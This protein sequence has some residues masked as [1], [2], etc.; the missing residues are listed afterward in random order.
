MPFLDAGMITYP[1]EVAE[2]I[3]GGTSIDLEFLDAGMWVNPLWEAPTPEPGDPVDNNLEFLDAGIFT[4]PLEVANLVATLPFNVRIRAVGPNVELV[5]DGQSVYKGLTGHLSS[6]RVGIIGRNNT[7]AAPQPTF[8]SLG[9]SQASKAPIFT[10]DIPD[11]QGLEAR[12]PGE[13]YAFNGATSGK[14]FSRYTSTT[15]PIPIGHTPGNAAETPSINVAGATVYPFYPEWVAGKA[16]SVG[17]KVWLHSN[18]GATNVVQMT[19]A[20][21]LPEPWNADPGTYTVVE[22]YASEY[23]VLMEPSTAQLLLHASDGNYDGANNNITVTADTVT[24]VV[25]GRDQVAV[26]NSNGSAGSIGAFHVLPS[27][28][29]YAGPLSATVVIQRITPTFTVTRANFLGIGNNQTIGVEYR[30]DNGECIPYGDVD[31]IRCRK[32]ADNLVM[33]Q[34]GG[35]ALV[36]TTI[37]W[38]LYIYPASGAAQA[39]DFATHIMNAATV[40]YPYQPIPD[41]ATRPANRVYEFA[42]MVEY[43]TDPGCANVSQKLLLIDSIPTSVQSIATQGVPVGSVSDLA[44]W[45]R[46]ASSGDSWRA[47]SGTSTA[48]TLPG[49]YVQLCDEYEN[50]GS[51]AIYGNNPG[52]AT[53]TKSIAWGTSLPP[54]LAQMT[55]AQASLATPMIIRGC[56]WWNQANVFN[57]DELFGPGAYQ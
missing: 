37:D 8:R 56:M 23:G 1:L 53:E 7:A 28:Q 3:G 13:I 40:N 55:F 19:Q 6:G 12:L 38:R 39:G 30:W 27:T 54:D 25:E 33:L 21:T 20:I 4:Y 9:V 34:F 24:S 17:D 44:N 16:V 51:R 50:G 22:P 48:I 29:G 15:L 42:D 31:W 41:Q 11:P 46:K 2:G 10:L 26:L 47:G 57:F 49:R 14:L 5:I 45:L 32:L 18:G 35:Q 36:G 52:E 43:Y